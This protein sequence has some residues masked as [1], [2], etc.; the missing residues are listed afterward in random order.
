[1]WWKHAFLFCINDDI[2]LL[3]N[4]ERF[5]LQVLFTMCCCRSL[6]YPFCFRSR[7]TSHALA[8]RQQKAMVI[9]IK[10]STTLAF[11]LQIFGV[12]DHKN[13]MSGHVAL[14]WGPEQLSLMVTTESWQSRC[15]WLSAPRIVV[16][17]VPTSM[18]FYVFGCIDWLPIYVCIGVGKMK[19]RMVHLHWI[20]S[21]QYYIGLL[22]IYGLM[23]F[24][25]SCI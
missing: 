14:Q 24:I 22:N 4:H 5:Y 16:L 3:H 15:H 2:K 6:R 1:M 21:I 25:R 10:S 7:H 20:Y 13:T 8:N 11:V 19:L 9:T 12:E 23:P 18:V 17:L